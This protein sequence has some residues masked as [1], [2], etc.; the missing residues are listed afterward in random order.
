MK[1]LI[2][3]L[4][5]SISSLFLG[6]FI[7]PQ[8]V[9]LIRFVDIQARPDQVW[10]SISTVQAW[11]SWDPYKKK[12]EGTSRPWKEGVLSIVSVDPDKQEIRYQITVDEGAGDL[13]LGMKPAGE[14]VT[15]RWHHSYVGGYWP[16]ERIVNW[17]DRSKLA[18]T[19]DEGLQ[20]LKQNVESVSK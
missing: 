19:F 1:T 15:L 2:V 12:S 9:E 17:F 6:L 8:K 20:Q 10:D 3:V 13:S 16:W 11:D 18:L 14:G 4:L 7:L 5:G